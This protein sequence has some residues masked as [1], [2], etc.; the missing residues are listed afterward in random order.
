M[1]VEWVLHPGVNGAKATIAV[2][3][4]FAILLGRV[5]EAVSQ[6]NA[7]GDAHGGEHHDDG[8]HA[9]Q[10]PVLHRE[11]LFVEVARLDKAL[12]RVDGAQHSLPQHKSKRLT[13]QT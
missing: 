3:V 6:H 5:V 8:E 13:V 7:E 11:V 10:A 12:L 2:V 9:R 1:R 4:V